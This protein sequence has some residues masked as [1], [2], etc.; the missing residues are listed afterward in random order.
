[1]AAYLEIAVNVPQV[2]GVFH[3]HAPPELEGCLAVG[4]LVEAPFGSQRV[5][6]VVLRFVDQPM[7][8]ETR[9]VFGLVDPQP[10][11]TP[12]QVALAGHLADT[13]LAPLSAF[14]GL[15][16]PSGLNQQVDT[17][18]DLADNGR[19]VDRK[20]SISDDIRR[21]AKDGRRTTNDGRW[22]TVFY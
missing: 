9:P 20:Q 7:V 19:R 15:M 8:P 11:L 5:Q 16:L 12:A 14:I 22:T 2:S 1:M 4:H 10:V 6:G 13:N 17:L 18:F 3:Y 21:N